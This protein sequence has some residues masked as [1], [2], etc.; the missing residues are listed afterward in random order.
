[1]HEACL[2]RCRT[3]QKLLMVSVNWNQIESAWDDFV[4]SVK[5]EWSTLTDDDLIGIGGKR[6]RLVAKLQ[7]R[8]GGSKGDVERRVND[9]L[10]RVS[11]APAVRPSET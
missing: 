8:Y 5:A 4:T 2:L 3:A 10:G 6:A 9:W 7:E 1:M 11:A